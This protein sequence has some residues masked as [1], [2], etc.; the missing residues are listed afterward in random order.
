MSPTS[1]QSTLRQLS[2]RL[3]PTAHRKCP[4]PAV[5]SAFYHVG[6][7]WLVLRQVHCC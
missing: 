7:S 2:V 5:T 3:E 1:K 4:D 6:T